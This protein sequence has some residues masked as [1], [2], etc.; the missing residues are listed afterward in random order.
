MTDGIKKWY[1]RT[2]DAE[3][4]PESEE[5]LVEWAEAGRVLPGQVLSS[6]RAHWR[7]V[8]SVPF[9]D[10]RFGIDMG[11]GQLRGPLNKMAAE[12]LLAS[13][14]LPPEAKVVE[15]RPPF[16]SVLPK[17]AGSGVDNVRVSELEE[18]LRKAEERATELEGTLKEAKVREES[19][20]TAVEASKAE[21][22]S[23]ASALDGMGKALEGVKSEL[24]ASKAAVAELEGKLRKSEDRA[25][26]FDEKLRKSEVCVTELEGKLRKAEERAAELEGTLK[27]AKAREESLRAAA[28][29]EKAHFETAKSELEEARRLISGLEER[30]KQSECRGAQLEKDLKSAVSREAALREELSRKMAAGLRRQRFASVGGEQPDGL[31]RLETKLQHELVAAKK[32]GIGFAYGLLASVNQTCAKRPLS[33]HKNRQGD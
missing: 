8:E 19:L 9:L 17:T 30:L 3:F 14:T 16:E 4:G 23:K 31:S 26:E 25:T 13:G 28:E 12:R 24:A 29:A 21:I 27:E 7:K 11:D 32:K 10:L 18:K 33:D 6:D 5:Q 15:V 2:D 22:A 20:R 1:L